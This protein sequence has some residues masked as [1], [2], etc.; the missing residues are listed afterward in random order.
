M[1]G[2]RYR[3]MLLLLVMGALFPPL[4]AEKAE[5][6][7]NPRQASGTF[8]Y[9]GGGV[10][11]PEYVKLIDDVCRDLQAK[12]TVELAVITVGNL[13]GVT[14]EE[15]SEQVFRRFGIG[16]VGKDNGLLLLCARDDRMVRLEVGYGLEAAIPDALASRLL[17]RSGLAY[18]KA[19]FFG[20]GLFMAVREI[21]GAA[22]TASGG[23]MFIAEPTAWPAE[24]VPPKPS[25]R[26]APK[27]KKG[28]DPLLSSLYF[29]VGLLGFAA[30]GLGWTLLRF[31]KAKG[32]A[33]R[34]KAIGGGIVPT[35][36]VWIAAVIGFFLVLGFGESF[37]QPFVAMLA[38]PG[39]ATAGQMLTSRFLR[40]R[41][42]S[43]RLPCSKC[44]AAMEMVDDSRDEEFLSEEQAA[45]E[46]AGGM[47]YEF[48]HCLKCGAEESLATKLGKASKCPQCKR[49]SLTSSTVTMVAATKEQ[50]GKARV[51][52]TC[53]NPKCNY[54]K[55]REHST[56]R[57]SSPTSASGSSSRSSAGSF[58]GGRSGGGGASKKF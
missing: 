20:R 30:L 36:L 15:F 7:L 58:G 19:G 37:F 39:L 22:A 40:R 46:K 24:A 48:W 25:S 21:A 34:A 10:L 23:V 38:A 11:A 16:A 33:A 55:I 13:G 45:E 1:H 49:R 31:N 43:Y 32:R 41:L 51:I 54:S 12:T 57:L 44:G 42:A 4:H 5:E 53:L 2:K 17:E 18:L 6:I 9:D 50:G 26:P 8:V 27:N 14:I 3:W 28:W 29:A 56:P 52:E 47:D 35:I